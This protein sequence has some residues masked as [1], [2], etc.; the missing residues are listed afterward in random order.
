VYHF[1][2]NLFKTE[3]GIVAKPEEVLAYED[4]KTEQVFPVDRVKTVYLSIAEM[5]NKND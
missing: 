1:H 2:G 4:F 3:Y 5:G